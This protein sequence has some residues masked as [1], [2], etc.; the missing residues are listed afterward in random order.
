MTPEEELNA[1]DV[2]IGDLENKKAEIMQKQLVKIK[3]K[4]I[5]PLIQDITWILRPGTGG[6]AFNLDKSYLKPIKTDEQKFESLS[7]KMGCKGYHFRDSFWFGKADIWLNDGDCEL[8]FASED[9]IFEFINEYNL[10]IDWS[11]V[12]E[13]SKKCIIQLS[14]LAEI[15]NKVNAT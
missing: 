9:Y 1:I 10:K 4:D 13:N 6:S 14:K 8:K 12:D 11:V 3:D 15:K 2:Q 7:D 5:Y